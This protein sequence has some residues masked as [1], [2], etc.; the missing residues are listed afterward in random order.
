MF[1]TGV[2]VAA[3][4]LL[5]VT[6]G[7]WFPDQGL[8]LGPLHWEKGVLMTGPSG[9]PD[10]L[11]PVFLSDKLGCQKPRLDLVYKST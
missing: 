6:C 2:L 1:H 5:V 3:C 9:S 11:M 7:I 10:G 4:G 8:S